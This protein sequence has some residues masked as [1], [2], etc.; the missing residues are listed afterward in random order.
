MLEFNHVRIAKADDLRG[1]VLASPPQTTIV[2]ERPGEKS[3]R[4]QEVTLYGNAEGM[5]IS[6]RVDDAEP[7]CVIVN[8]VLTGSPAQR[9]GI[10]LNDRIEKVG[11]SS[12]D[13]EAR[14]RSLLRQQD[15]PFD[16]EIERSG[17]DRRIHVEIAPR[18]KNRGRAGLL[19]ARN[20]AV[21]R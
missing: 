17:H 21:L 12:F 14:F 5:G 4:T 2:F 9:A 10:K 16:L 20:N 18:A 1:A 15:A 3:P 7:G 8:R 13:S 6:W 19:G 11:K